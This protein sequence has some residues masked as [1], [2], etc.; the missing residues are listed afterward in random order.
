MKEDKSE[1]KVK[2]KKANVTKWVEWDSEELCALYTHCKRHVAAD[3]FS[4][5]RK[6]RTGRPVVSG[7][8]GLQNLGACGV[9]PKH[10]PTA[11]QVRHRIHV[12]VLTNPLPVEWHLL[13]SLS[14]GGTRHG[15]CR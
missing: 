14:C 7:A 6:S 11:A 5:F 2:V 13:Y 12:P 4:T 1:V 8:V 9:P 15:C 10:A 3:T